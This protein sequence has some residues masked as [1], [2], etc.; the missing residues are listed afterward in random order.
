MEQE[1]AGQVSNVSRQM[2]GEL[3]KWAEP[4]CVTM[5]LPLDPGHPEIGVD[6]LTLKDLVRDARR[7]LRAASGLRSPAIDE[8]LAPAD[9]LLAAEWWP[10]G[11]RGYAFFS[12]PGLSMHLQLDVDVP[13]LSVVADRFV[14]TPLVAAIEH[15]D[16][17]YVLALSQNRVR[18]LR[19]NHGGLVDAPVPGLPASRADALWYEHH[20]RQTNVH[21][22]SHQG[23]DRTIGTVHGSPS[24]HD[25]RKDQLLRFFR[26][27]DDKLRRVLREEPA[28]LFVAGVDY[29]L[30]IYREANRFP[31]L[32]GLLDTG[33]PERLSTGQLHDRVWPAA[34]S[35]LDSPRRALLDR[36]EQTPSPLTSIRAILAA[37]RERRVAALLVAPNRLEWGQLEA[38]D[39]HPVHDSDDVDLVSVVIGAAL[40]QGADLYR[41]APG[42]LKGD[43]AVAAVA[44]Y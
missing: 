31:H 4:P 32:A 7:R 30:A 20:E 12:G 37:C 6:R 26:I 36:V 34:A 23:A 43:P 14:V 5:Y 18:F 3:A 33:N 38:A 21:G 44:R 13:T 9:A 27:V 25:L 10:L 24:E 2:L 35:V 42:E 15:D 11:C 22:G 1:V 28:P 39:G 17:F 40:E 8:L 41:L 19:G 29:E 16:R